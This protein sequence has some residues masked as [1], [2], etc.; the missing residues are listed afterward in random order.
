MEPRSPGLAIL[1]LYGGW[2]QRMSGHPWTR[3]RWTRGAVVAT[4][5][6]LAAVGFCMF[7]GDYD[8]DHHAGSVHVCL[9]MV[10]NSLARTAVIE[11][12]VAG[13][14]VVLSLH[15]L[16]VLTLGVPVPPPKFIVS[17]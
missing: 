17:L 14:A 12:L 6:L 2:S 15:R 11:L 1:L 9:A 13:S 16:T 3:S 4:L 8:G 7:E 10:G 5:I